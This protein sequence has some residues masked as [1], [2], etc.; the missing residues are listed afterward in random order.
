[1]C[2]R[3]V[4]PLRGSLFYPTAN[5][6][7]TGKHKSMKPVLVGHSQLNIAAEGGCYYWLPHFAAF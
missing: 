1:M 5:D 4:E 7:M 3:H 2:G 6:T